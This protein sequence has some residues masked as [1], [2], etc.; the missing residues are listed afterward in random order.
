M[1]QFLF[2]FASV[3]HFLPLSIYFFQ[4]VQHFPF[5]HLVKHHKS[6]EVKNEDSCF[7]CKEPGNEENRRPGCR[8]NPHQGNAL[9]I[10]LLIGH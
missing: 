5:I 4:F 6:P 1:P 10:T 9:I 2:Y 8:Q 7:Q 3:P